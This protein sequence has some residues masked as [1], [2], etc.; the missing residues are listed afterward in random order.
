MEART[1]LDEDA[2]NK[3]ATKLVSKVHNK[4]RGIMQQPLNSWEI[5]IKEREA[6][7]A[8]MTI[9]KLWNFLPGRRLRRIVQKMMNEE[10]AWV[11]IDNKLLTNKPD[12]TELAVQS[13]ELA[14]PAAERAN[15]DDVAEMKL[16]SPLKRRKCEGDWFSTSPI[17]PM[18]PLQT[19][20]DLTHDDS[21]SCIVIY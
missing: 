9:H 20:I 8:L 6:V 2:K 3:P 17:S 15:A 14:G 10:P 13:A 4:S 11:N 19:C 7:D 1:Q 12:Y 16:M 21:D 18:P 5:R